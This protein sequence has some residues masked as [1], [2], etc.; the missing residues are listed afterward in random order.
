[1]PRPAES[2]LIPLVQ[3]NAPKVRALGF[4]HA[5]SITPQSPTFL[6]VFIAI[7]Q[8]QVSGR[9]LVVTGVFGSLYVL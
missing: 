4:P 9:I 5:H 8:G 1:M 6:Q 3:M 2:P 7:V